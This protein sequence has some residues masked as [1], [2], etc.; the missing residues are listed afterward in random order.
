MMFQREEDD[1]YE[2]DGKERDEEFEEDVNQG[3]TPK[4]EGNEEEEDN[5]DGAQFVDTNPAPPK[6]WT[7]SQQAQQDKQ[8]SALVIEI[9]SDNEKQQRSR[10]EVQAASKRSVPPSNSQPSSQGEGGDPVPKE[11]DLQ[12]PGNEDES[13]VKGVPNSTPKTECK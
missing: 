4:D 1:N 2:K 9:L 13:V 6:C 8:E 3:G 11:A 5:E 12:K 7:Q 10:V